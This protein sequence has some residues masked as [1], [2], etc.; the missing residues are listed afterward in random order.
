MVAA[1][2]EL[3]GEDEIVDQ[4]ARVLARSSFPT[5]DEEFETLG[6]GAPEGGPKVSTPEV[7]KRLS[8]SLRDW[9]DDDGSVLGNGKGSGGS[10][11]GG[12]GGGSPNVTVSLRS[13]PT[14]YEVWR[15]KHPG[16]A[17]SPPSKKF[18]PKDWDGLV[19][20]L[21]ASNKA[22][23]ASVNS[24]QNANLAGELKDLKFEPALCARSL[25]LEN[26]KR[27]NTTMVDMQD[28]M[29]K[30]FEAR[31]AKL[32]ERE[33]S[34]E[35]RD[36]TFAPRLA[37]AAKSTAYLRQSHGSR[38]TTADLQSYADEA[39]VR[40]LQRKQLVEDVETRDLTFAPTLNKKSMRITAKLKAEGKLT[41]DPA[42]KQTAATAHLNSSSVKKGG[43][44][45]A[46]DPGHEHE[47][48]APT[49]SARAKTYATRRDE[50]DVYDR[51]YSRAKEQVAAQ[52][53]DAVALLETYVD[54]PEAFK[55]WET[56]K[57][58]G[59]LGE[60]RAAWAKADGPRAPGAATGGGGA[61]H[62][63]VLE[64]DRDLDD[65]LELVSM[66]R[67]PADDDAADPPP[68]GDDGDD[69]DDDD[70]NYPEELSTRPVPSTS[71]A[72]PRGRSEPQPR[73][74]P[75]SAAPRRRSTAKA[76]KPSALFDDVPDDDSD[77]F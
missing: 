8:V 69:G 43:T 40:R 68:P 63:D 59:A 64:Y 14:P 54:M 60:A 65:L 47:T 7:M 35:L 77:L 61:P 3:R 12:G 9:G 26:A 28:G 31:I 5:E 16:P 72:R 44:G 48:F 41:V 74:R 58:D 30:R 6:A 11:R 22:R 42:S 20:R 33:R 23:E 21:Y 56:T 49:I 1:T 24:K 10:P 62:V 45:S 38:R 75:S 66:A 70:D 32:R 17:A 57:V 18:A 39:K 27:K 4:L 52:H 71:P 25:R 67:L 50:A 19:A 55:T 73:A 34:E 2:D 37:A 76:P 13:G 36:C 46:A 15:A 29:R 53:N 51:L